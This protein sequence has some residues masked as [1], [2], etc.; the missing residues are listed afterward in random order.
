MSIPITLLRKKI[1]RINYA[2]KLVKI[3]FLNVV[4][5]YLKTIGGYKILI[6][7]VM[8]IIIDVLNSLYI[9][10]C[11]FHISIQ[12]KIIHFKYQIDDKLEMFINKQ[13]LIT[14]FNTLLSV[15]IE[16]LKKYF[17]RWSLLIIFVCVVN[18]GWKSKHSN[19]QVKV[20]KLL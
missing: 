13:K 19:N 16:K 9:S 8:K 20:R 15:L 7:N 3:I 1:L 6:C 5:T 2:V 14:Y 12:H 10:T 11:K 18:N 4:S 17:K